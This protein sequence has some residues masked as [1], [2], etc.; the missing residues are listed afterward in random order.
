[1]KEDCMG[2]VERK[3]IGQPDDVMEMEKGRVEIVNIAGGGVG[4]LTLQPGW[5]WE[6]HEKPLFNTDWCEIPHFLYV[7]QGNLHVRMRDGEEFDLKAGDVCALP[8]GHDGWVVGDE[9][10]VGVDWS[11]VTSFG[12]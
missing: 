3:S 1:M 2:S 8:A 12:K 9:P 5:E 6:K 7:T 4:R 11:G 10:V